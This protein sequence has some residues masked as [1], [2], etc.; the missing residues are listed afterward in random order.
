LYTLDEETKEQIER[1]EKLV[2]LRSRI[3][4]H[5]VCTVSKLE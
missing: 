2:I 4:V 1:R 5:R 3:N